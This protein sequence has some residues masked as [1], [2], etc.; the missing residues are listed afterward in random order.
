MPTYLVTGGCGFIGSHI[1]EALVRRGDRAR[2]LDDLSSGARGTLE[3][4]GLGDLGDAGS[5]A[6]IEL[7][8]GDV[9]DAARAAEACRGVRGVFHEAALVSVPR[10]VEEPELSFRT[11]VAGTFELLRAARDAGAGSFVLASSS[12]VY[13]DDA[14]VPK[15]ETMPP[16]PVSPYAGDKLMAETLLA[17]WGRSFGLRTVALRYFN[18][19]GPRQSDDSP[20]SGVIALF[21]R[22]CLEERGVTIYGDG[23]QSRDFVFVE[24]V[25]R[26]NLLAMDGAAPAGAVLNVGSGDAVTVNRLLEEV[27]AAVGWGEAPRYEA[28]RPGDVRH[29]LASIDAL[30]SQLGF[31]PRVS[32]ADGLAR[33]VAWYRGRS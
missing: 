11:N 3:G 32:R 17:V 19:F 23:E 30:R 16:E 4:L 15:L 22:A 1:V 26:A 31:S 7:V 12:A 24:D 2:V 9:A 33:T 29:S 18:V 21:V 13:G 27:S 8:V 10:S 28:A 25:V 6:P 20:Y 5:G 14:T